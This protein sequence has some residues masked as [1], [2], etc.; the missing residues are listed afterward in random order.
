ML[1]ATPQLSP[2]LRGER[3]QAAGS[4]VRDGRRLLCQREGM[5]PGE[6]S[7]W[8]GEMPLD[9]RQLSPWGRSP[10]S[11][12]APCQQ[13][14]RPDSHETRRPGGAGDRARALPQAGTGR[15]AAESTEP[16]RA[17]RGPGPRSGVGCP[18]SR[19][20]REPRSTHPRAGHS[21]GARNVCR[22]DNPVKSM[23]QRTHLDLSST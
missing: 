12:L 11:S 2:A 7:P 20:R 4:P 15:A 3:V 18:A 21:L 19:S 6:L 10:G 22:R 13:L 16:P 9:R 23:V 17:A 5:R 8:Q 1:R 14:L